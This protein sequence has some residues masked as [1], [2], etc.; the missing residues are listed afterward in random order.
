MFVRPFGRTHLRSPTALAATRSQHIP[1]SVNIHTRSQAL[2][3]T[4][5]HTGQTYTANRNGKSIQLDMRI[6]GVVRCARSYYTIFVRACIIM[7]ERPLLHI[8]THVRHVLM[9]YVFVTC[10]FLHSPSSI[11]IFRVFCFVCCSAVTTA[12]KYG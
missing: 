3:H 6:S 10:L 8:N 9:G 2:T 1:T 7:F 4:D 11:D 5:T 12:C